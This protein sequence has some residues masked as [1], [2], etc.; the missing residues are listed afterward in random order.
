MTCLLGGRNDDCCPTMRISQSEYETRTQP[1]QRMMQDFE[2]D[3]LLPQ[4]AGY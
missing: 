3:A 4:N 2:I 1:A